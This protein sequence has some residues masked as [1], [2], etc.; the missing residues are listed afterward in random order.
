MQKDAI[1]YL[2]IHFTLVTTVSN[3]IYTIASVL[4]Q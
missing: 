3:M 4:H 2:T 1:S